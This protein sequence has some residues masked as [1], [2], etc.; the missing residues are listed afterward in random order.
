MSEF[1]NNSNA[2]AQNN[3]GG[4]FVPPVP[5]VPTVPTV[6]DPPIPTDP[7]E[8]EP[9]IPQEVQM[10]VELQPVVTLCINKPIIKLKNNAVCIC[11][12]CKEKV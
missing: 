4:A 9:C 11:T 3:Q 2:N 7:C 5:T 1:E 10:N 6:E 12:P 8:P